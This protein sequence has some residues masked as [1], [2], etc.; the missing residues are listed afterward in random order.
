MP[1]DPSI[2]FAAARVPEIPSPLESYGRAMALSQMMAQ[3]KMLPARLRAIDLA[4]REQE[5]QNRQREQ[6]MRDDDII[7]QYQGHWDGDPD[8]FLSGLRGQISPRR[9]AD[10]SSHVLD[11]KTKALALTEGQNKIERE[12]RA[13]VGNEYAG[14]LAVPPEQQAG[15]WDAAQD[16]LIAAKHLSPEEKSPYP[17]ADAVRTLLPGLD[18]ETKFLD[19][20]GKHQQQKNAAEQEKRAAELHPSKKQEAEAKAES[21]EATAEQDALNRAAN[22]LAAAARTGR[23]SYHRTR[24]DLKERLGDR[25][26]ETPEEGDYN[27]EDLVKQ[28]HERALTSAQVIASRDRQAR[29]GSGRPLEISSTTGTFL[30]WPTKPNE[31]PV[32]QEVRPY[33]K[34]ITKQPI[35]GTTPQDRM[36][37][38]AAR[39]ELQRGIEAERAIGDEIRASESLI[40][41]PKAIDPNTKVEITPEGRA[42]HQERIAAR[43]KE[44]A[45]LY[46]RRVQLGFSKPEDVGFPKTA[47]EAD[48]MEQNAHQARTVAG[49]VLSTANGAEFSDPYEKDEKKRAK[50][51]TPEVR[52]DWMRKFRA[53]TQSMLNAQAG[54]RNLRSVPA[55]STAPTGRPRAVNPQT[56][57]AVEWDGTAWVPAQ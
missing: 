45:E 38:Q 57:E 35:G 13:Q 30:V 44:L 2:I 48:T 39:T 16:R 6:D 24:N 43:Q 23:A 18:A 7:R 40:A 10:L 21:A 11:Y 32:I 37:E 33:G 1:L 5:M 54:R 42:A 22:A 31:P 25:F 34:P 12:R 55:A 15:V 50:T 26:P 52:A 49:K 27:A 9:Y 51:M 4:N 14:V 8:K 28:I 29:T 36:R 20:A 56:G 53:A 41:T 19:W 46:A 17:G 3:Q 47:P